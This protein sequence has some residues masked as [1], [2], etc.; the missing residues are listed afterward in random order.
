MAVLTRVGEARFKRNRYKVSGYDMKV[1]SESKM[2][3]VEY[4]AVL[5]KKIIAR[6]NH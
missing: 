6:A 2:A 3:P 5:L 1:K 4:R